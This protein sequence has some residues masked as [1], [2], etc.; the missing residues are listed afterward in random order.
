MRSLAVLSIIAFALDARAFQNCPILGLSFPTPKSL[1]T[2][3]LIQDASANL[4][5][6][7]EQTLQSGQSLDF[8][9]S[10]S[11]GIFSIASSD[12]LF[13]YH[14]S[15]PSL[16]NSTTGVT[17][18]DADTIYRIGS[19]SKLL[20]VF[21]YLIELGDASW[22]D[23]VTKYIPEL[24]TASGSDPVSSAAWADITV[25]ALAAQ[26]SGIGRDN[27]LGDLYSPLTAPSAYTSLGLPIL[28]ASD[29]SLC[30]LTS[31]ET[32]TRADFFKGLFGR[33]AVLASF[34]TAIYS[35]VAYQLFGYVLESITGKPFASSIE[36]SLFT[37][38]NMSSSSFTVPNDTSR[39]VIPVSPDASLWNLDLGD[40][41][42]YGGMF[43]TLSDIA[44]LGR[45]ILNSTLLSPAQTRRWL[46]P[47]SHTA[48]LTY[49]VG[50]PWEIQ[51][52]ILPLENRVVDVY[53][54]NGD[55]GS[56]FAF[57]ALIPE[58]GVGF[59]ALGASADGGAPL[60]VTVVSSLIG[61][62]FVP[63]EARFAGTFAAAGLNSSITLNTEAGRPG[64]GVSRWISNGTD[65]L[66]TLE[67]SPFTVRLY[68][69]TLFSDSR[70]AFRAVYEE[71]FD[72][73]GP[74]PAFQDRCV[75]WGGVD[76]PTYG[77]V[78]FD[79]FVFELGEDGV[80]VSVEPRFLRV[81]L[82]RTV[83]GTA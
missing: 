68:P 79:D 73:T 69:T 77:T 11:V 8:N 70:Y 14:H 34:T 41:T 62:N 50:A 5:A 25:G 60:D 13:Q 64:L 63:A 67:T 55:L 72:N 46:K 48:S 78:A 26:L 38:L 43:S 52:L 12:L 15:A 51:R 1:S 61:D 33:H 83:D 59:A 6:T 66:V 80:A 27:G 21:T 24:Q 39:G 81:G 17:A 45:A 19:V 42:P 30:N 44:K 49:S 20:T 35:N 40:G 16:V 71:T 7:I 65:M 31:A 76:T 32:C 75:T 10:F 47:H 3:S 29:A 9:T 54:K 36:S 82:Q 58:Y 37:P 23:P 53:T 18:V 22:S 56:Y 74:T 2:S 28:N 57:F 4:T